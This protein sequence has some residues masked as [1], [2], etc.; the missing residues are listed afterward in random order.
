[1]RFCPSCGV[2][3]VA[4]FCSGC[5]FD[6]DQTAEPELDTD[7][8]TPSF[9]AENA[10]GVDTQA[11]LNVEDFNG[12]E[13]P[14]E[15][16][17]NSMKNLI[18]EEEVSELQEQTLSPDD[19][20]PLGAHL[21]A[22]S[23]F[24][25]GTEGAGQQGTS[26]AQVQ[27]GQIVQI[28]EPEPTITVQDSVQQEDKELAVDKEDLIGVA[29]AQPEPEVVTAAPLKTEGWYADPINSTRFRYWDGSAWTDRT[30]M[31]ASE[32]EPEKQP[33]HVNFELAAPV[34]LEGLT[35]GKKYRSGS[36][37]FNCGFMTTGMTNFCECC[38]ASL[39]SSE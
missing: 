21:V 25:E 14:E 17:S 24:E 12:T 23:A 9:V 16:T 15:K 18:T 5:G 28:N 6:F 33:E 1:M 27:Q 10:L 26:E 8:E 38:G 37:C 2:E 22:E 31:K 13:A 30:A 11:E 39:K 32:V 7:Q 34:V 19:E 36:S 4:R 20:A 3:R 29:L 35:Y